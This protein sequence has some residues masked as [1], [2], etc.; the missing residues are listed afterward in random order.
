VDDAVAAAAPYV[1]ELFAV[2]QYWLRGGAAYFV[3]TVEPYVDTVATKM[4]DVALSCWYRAV[5]GV[6]PS[7]IAFKGTVIGAG[8]AVGV[9]YKEE[10]NM[11]AGAIGAAL[12]V[13]WVGG[14]LTST[15]LSGAISAAG[16]VSWS[17]NKKRKIKN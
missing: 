10:V 12:A 1:H 14:S 16:T 13:W 9:Y 11:V 4:S 2:S 7:V 6:E 8:L 17:S 5:D 3:E 15:A